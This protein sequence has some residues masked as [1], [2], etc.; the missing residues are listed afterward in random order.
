MN[1]RTYETEGRVLYQRFA[2][3]VAAIL[4]AAI[5][6][7]PELRLQHIQRRAK[8]LSSLKRKLEARK[9]LDNEDI[10]A[11][12]KDLAGC[13]L[14]FYTNSDVRSF[15]LSGILPD[16]FV[17]EWDRI[18]IH[19]PHA[20]TKE[21][22]ELFISDNYV[23]RLKDDRLALPEYTE[24]R[25]LSCE[26]QVQTTLNHAWSEMAHDTIYKMP[27][28]KG[29][30][31]SLMA[32]IETRM[33]KI[34]REHLLPA[35]YEF[36]KVVDDFERLRSGKQLFDED[37]LKQ[38][39]A[40]DDNN[41]RY[42]L[43]KRFE[44]YVLPSYDDLASVQAG[45]RAAVVNAIQQAY[46]T[47]PRPLETPFINLPGY[48]ADTVLEAGAEILDYIRYYDVEVTLDALCA[49][50]GAITSQRARKRLLTS[51]QNLA[52]HN[53]EIWR[54]AGPAVQLRLVEHLRRTDRPI[55]SSARP[56]ILKVLDEILKSEITGS[57]ATYRTLTLHRGAAAPSEGLDL[58]RQGAI[59]VLK[60][61][62]REASSD[63]E[64]L[65]VT[66]TFAAAMHPPHGL[67]DE[68]RKTL[69]RDTADI[70]SFYTGVAP[71]LSY[72]LLEHLEHT[73][74]WQ[75]RHKCKP[76]AQESDGEIAVLR[77]ELTQR[78]LEFR[79]LVNADRTFV[80]YKTLVGFESVFP[81]EWEGDSLDVS[82][83]EAYR[84][85][86]VA[87]FVLQVTADTAEEWYPI[88]VRCAQTE[89]RDGATFIS[90]GEFLEALAQS[91][92]QVVMTYLDRVDDSLANFLPSMLSG[93]ERGAHKESVV[94]RIRQWVAQ[95]KYLG[96]VIWY[97]RYALSVDADVLEHALNAAIEVGG[98]LEVLKALSA[99][100]ARYG[101][102]PGQALQ[103]VFLRALEYLSAKNI[104]W[105]NAALPSVNKNTLFKDLTGPQVDAVMTSLLHSP[106]VTYRTEEILAEIA[107]YSPYKVIDFFGNRLAQEL[108]DTNGDR[109]EAI[110]YEFHLLQPMLKDYP[111]YAVSAAQAWYARDPKL[112]EYRGGRFLA[113][114]FPAFTAEYE[115]VLAKI[116]EGSSANLEFI[117]HTLRSYNGQTFTHDLT[118]SVIAALPTDDPLLRQLAL[119]L[120]STGVLRGEFG[121]VEAYRQKNAD[122]ETWLSD[123]RERVRDFA[124]R[125]I[126]VLEQQIAGEQ[127]RSEED[128]EF[129]K[130]SYPE[131]SD[132]EK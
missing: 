36:Q 39:V 9:A 7:K 86:R 107:K 18:K 40:C 121:L 124:K 16:N 31:A 99:A 3:A 77:S 126:Y 1:F 24:F 29:F 109:Y 83:R 68:L 80:I 132:A 131:S 78:I 38:L 104:A 11:G 49:L 17:V 19:H 12:V 21:A 114:I 47:E 90:F 79:H 97:E 20:E 106:E 55:L 30:G 128:L 76:P 95:R 41:T 27:E 73:L 94:D 4:A 115:N 59:G 119:A 84:K 88:I 112:F 57:T 122:M 111:E 85:E 6:Q 43:L 33:K 125:H 75:Y 13:R 81:P 118:K 45:V 105:V 101:D 93:L 64:R 63:D 56:V 60:D 113:N 54:Q 35:G 66:R 87:D 72:E 65:A 26:V 120:D 69:L 58:A 92:P 25:S 116:T 98:D 5:G 62:F 42:E 46:V 61:L 91:S 44:E 108:P 37:A 10:G 8:A 34:M 32:G 117:V 67:S 2:D 96:Q 110:P 71:T 70:V 100:A 28:L 127:R 130:R 15:Q 22:A 103:R 82:G 74:L 23:V 53:L 129:R 48:N 89:S 102:V 51:A 50:F 52:E 14:V 123:D